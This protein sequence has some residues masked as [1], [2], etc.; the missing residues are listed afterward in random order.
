MKVVTMAKGP[1]ATEKD[2]SHMLAV[3]DDMR[4]RVAAGQFVAF[5]AV[6]IDAGDACYGFAGADRSEH[7]SRLRM[8]GAIS[9]LLHD[10]IAGELNE[11]DTIK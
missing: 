6:A 2:P 8:Q 10:Y 3:I 4:A 5:S 7:V 1:Y 11:G 9:Q